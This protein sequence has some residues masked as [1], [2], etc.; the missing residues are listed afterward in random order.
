M[1]FGNSTLF[2]LVPL[3]VA[4]RRLRLVMQ[5]REDVKITPVTN[6]SIMSA[7]H[8]NGLVRQVNEL[9]TRLNELESL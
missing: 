1:F 2:V 3:V 9:S 7:D 5:Q 6:H 8:M 4:V